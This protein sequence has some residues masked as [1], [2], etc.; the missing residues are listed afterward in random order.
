MVINK[1]FH[2]GFP[3]LLCLV[4]A[5]CGNTGND[6]GHLVKFKL[7]EYSF[8]DKTLKKS[9][10]AA[11][12]E[13]FKEEP[14]VPLK[15]YFEEPCGLL[16][17][18]IDVCE[19]PMRFSAVAKYNIKVETFHYGYYGHC[20]DSL[21]YYKDACCMLGD[22]LCYITPDKRYF[23]KTGRRKKIKFITYDGVCPCTEGTLYLNFVDKNKIEVVPEDELMEKY[24]GISD[25]T[26]FNSGFDTL[27][28]AFQ[29]ALKNN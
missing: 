16:A 21:G 14:D 4:L 6:D 27:L 12:S 7:D 29:D 19:E 1:V 15:I 5:G 28:A 3:L 26:T 8:I 11:V 25:I 22:H 23:E 9:I 20:I 2:W 24:G 10:E 13:Q 18:V 17:K